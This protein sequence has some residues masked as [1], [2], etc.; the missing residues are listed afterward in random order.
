[1]SLRD[2]AQ[3]RRARAQEMDLRGEQIAQAKLQNADTARLADEAQTTRGLLQINDVSTPEGQAQFLH[4]MQ[5]PKVGLGHLVPEW[6]QKFAAQNEAAKKAKQAAH[7]DEI[8]SNSRLLNGVAD[9]QSYQAAKNW[10]NKLHGNTDGLPDTYDPDAIKMYLGHAMSY[11][12]QIEQQNK[13]NDRALKEKELTTSSTDKANALAET[14][15][16]NIA[17][18]GIARTNAATEAAKAKAPKAPN[19]QQSNAALFGRRV[20]QA[21]ND[22][23]NLSASGFNRADMKNGAMDNKF[24]PNAFTPA[25]LQSQ[26]QAER[27][28]VNAVLRRESGAAISPSEFSSAEKQYFPRAGDSKAVLEQKARNRQLVLEGLKS[29][30]GAA[31]DTIAPIG[32]NAAPGATGTWDSS[33]GGTL[34]KDSNGELIYRPGGN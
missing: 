8:E 10:I 25:D 13:V 22:M 24:F 3:M 6:Q 20:E 17:S 28:F 14:K 33:S 34:E 12:D 16:H 29:A 2:A 1:M 18:E 32:I 31:W 15:R 19:E 11:K 23:K 9:E 30:A 26:Q 21:I 5:G 7:L 4:D 27:N